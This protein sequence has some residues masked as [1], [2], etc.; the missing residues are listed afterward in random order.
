[1]GRFPKKLFILSFLILITVSFMFSQAVHYGKLAGKV[2][3]DQGKPLPGVS[4]TVLSDALIK[5]KL[6]TITSD[7]GKYY[8][9]SLPIGVYTVKASLEGFESKV[10]K[11]VEILAGRVLVIDFSLKLGQISETIVVKS[12]APIIDARTATTDQTVDS[13]MLKS[14]PTSRDAFYDLSTSTP[15]MF[16]VGSESSWL[17]SPTAYGGAS[18]ENV[19]LVNGV[20]TTN[21]RSGAFGSLVNVNYSAVKEVRIIALGT[22]AEYGNFSGVAID[23]IT[24]SGSN[25]FHGNLGFF[26]NLG[27]VSSNQPSAG[28]NLGKDWLYINSNDNVF[29]EPTKD[30]EYSFTLGGPIVKNALWFYTGVDYVDSRNK[31]PFFTPEKG[32]KGRYFDFKLTGQAGYNL[33]TW[34]SYHFENN[35]NKNE[36]WGTLGWD[37]EVVYNPNFKT[38]SIAAEIQWNVGGTTNFTTK[39]LGF[40]NIEKSYLPDNAPDNP[41][42]IN[43]WKWVAKDMG[44]NGAFPWVE[45]YRNNRQTVQAD[46]SS[47]TDK[48]LGEHDMK[49]GVQYTKAKGNAFNGYF[50]G[51]GLNAYPYA[52]DQSVDYMQDSFGGFPMYVNKVTKKPYLT[53]RSANSLGVFFDDQWTIGDRFTINIGMRYDRMTSKFEKGKIYNQPTDPSKMYD[54]TVLRERKGSDNIFDFKTFSPRIGFAYMLTKD[55]K[56]VFRASYGRYYVPISVETL[57]EG[58][59][60]MDSVTTEYMY[61]TLPM[62]LVDLNGDGTI[63]SDE[64]IA[65]TRLLRGRDADWSETSVS[66]PSY[67]LNVSKNLKNQYTDQFTVTFEREILT[68]LKFSASYI[69]KKTKNMIVRWPIDKNTGK[70]WNTITVPYTTEDGVNMN[71]HV[72]PFSDFNGDGKI[73]GSDVEY[74]YNAGNYEWTNMPK[75]DGV[76]PHRTYK[77]LQFVLRKRYSN[78]WQM[79]MSFLYSDSDGVAGRNKRQDQDLNIEAPSFFGG[80]YFVSDYN[81][82]LNNMTGPLPFVPKYEFKVNASYTIPKIEVDVGFRFRYNSG[83]PLWRITDI[84]LDQLSDYSV[85]HSWDMW[86][87]EFDS[88]SIMFCS[89]EVQIL[90]MDSDKPKYTPANKIL[91]LHISKSFKLGSGSVDIG[92]DILNVFNEGN[93]TNVLVKGDSFGRVT[94]ITYPPRLIRFNLSYEF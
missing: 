67:M 10:Q 21:P 72:V 19:F 17:P 26:S 45:S 75:Y 44:I 47:Y 33:R 61:Y 35:D 40:W 6:S 48:F 41:A 29:T 78:R 79:M 84:D 14:L 86:N 3:D 36:S 43:W 53:V 37:P 52:W 60:D 57:G 13:K 76:D 4:V 62:N 71:L 20:N 64:V 7:D 15:G 30:M 59:P 5:G 25:K 82:L 70:E 34:I 94:G 31:V 87:D 8:F 91:D 39:Y 23:V 73:D 83:R 56:T 92:F 66:D 63:D 32:Y 46:V 68:D 42:Y 85:L 50:H 1:M 9:S 81:Q 74:F 80:D 55:A 28:A 58:G 27:S 11:G 16:D 77:G 54:A 88:N 89:D 38:H 49:F 51:Y 24:K 93:I 69:Y 2:L 12:K 65:A 90:S 22:K 18:N